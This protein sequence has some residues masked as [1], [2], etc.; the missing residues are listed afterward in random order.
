MSLSGF[1]AKVVGEKKRWRTYRARVKR[2]PA[3]YRDTVDAVQ[4]YLMYSGHTPTDG[5]RAATMFEDL[6]DLFEAAAADGT[7]I[8]ADEVT[9]GSVFHVI[10]EGIEDS[11]HPLEEKAKAVVLLVRMEAGVVQPNEEREGWDVDGI[12]AYS[13]VCTH[14]G[15]PVALYE[16][17]THHLLCPCH[18]STFDLNTGNPRTLPATQPVDVFPVTTD[19][20]DIL[21]EV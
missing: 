11:E 5:D 13:K 6:A 16:Q 14:V 17:L 3:P 12:Y 21:I 9:I 7:P 15:C 4:R 1:A 2:L 18:G 8:R 10:P 20:D 19:G